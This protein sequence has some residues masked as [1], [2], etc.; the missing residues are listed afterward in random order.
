M[1]SRLPEDDCRPG[2]SGFVMHVV[3]RVGDF[4]DDTGTDK[5]S[6]D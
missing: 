1:N 6:V 3:K 4:A 5:A 2:I